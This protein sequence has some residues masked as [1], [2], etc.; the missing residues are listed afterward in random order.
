MLFLAP[1][2]ALYSGPQLLVVVPFLL[3]LPCL[4]LHQTNQWIKKI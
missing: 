3:D 4:H 1:T 2:G